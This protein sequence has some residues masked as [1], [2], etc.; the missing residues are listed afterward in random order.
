MRTWNKT[1]KTI[2]HKNLAFT[3]DIAAV[4]PTFNIF[5]YNASPS[6]GSATALHVNSNYRVM[7]YTS[8]IAAVG[9]IQLITSLTMRLSEI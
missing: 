3:F 5:S 1:I 9:T 6:K 8:D 2:L 7:Y 4:G